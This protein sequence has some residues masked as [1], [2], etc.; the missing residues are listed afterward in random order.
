MWLGTF[1]LA[2]C[3]A[4]TFLGDYPPAA[5]FMTFGAGALFGKG[6]GI[7]EERVKTIETLKATKLQEGNTE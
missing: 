6:Y 2:F 1:I 5:V 4:I 3:V 7:W